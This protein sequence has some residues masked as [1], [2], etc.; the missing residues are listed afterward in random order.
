MT[1][2]LLTPSIII[3][4]T[5]RISI[6][7]ASITPQHQPRRSAQTREN[8]IPDN[9]ARTSAEESIPVL[10]LLFV[11]FVIRV[12]FPRLVST[13]VAVAVTVGIVVAGGVAAMSTVV[14]ATAVAGW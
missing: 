14:S 1:S 6:L 3:T 13:G 10:V 11:C 9:G 5:P 2:L 12:R 8:G 7:S 4:L